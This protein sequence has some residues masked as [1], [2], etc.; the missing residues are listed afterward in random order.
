MAVRSSEWLYI[1]TPENVHYAQW[2]LQ[3]SDL[4]SSTQ[5]LAAGAAEAQRETL[6]AALESLVGYRKAFDE[7]RVLTEE[8]RPA[9]SR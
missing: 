6:E 3:M 2:M 4:Q 1:R 5:A 8:T 7:F 9:T